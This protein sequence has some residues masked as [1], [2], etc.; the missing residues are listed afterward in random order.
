MRIVPAVGTTLSHGLQW[1]GLLS[2][3]VILVRRGDAGTGEVVCCTPVLSG[4]G[5]P[6]REGIQNV[7]ATVV[8]RF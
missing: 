3:I 6:S 5:G 1:T 4:G 2:V 7:T 8:L